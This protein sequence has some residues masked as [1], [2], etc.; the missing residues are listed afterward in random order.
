[1]IRPAK[2]TRKNQGRLVIPS[3]SGPLVKVSAIVLEE[4]IRIPTWITDLDSFRRW[5][6][7]DEFP[8]HGW[9]SYLDGDLWADPSLERLI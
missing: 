5:A 9:Y 1:M 4:S 7:S 8:E 6:R 3:P 2:E